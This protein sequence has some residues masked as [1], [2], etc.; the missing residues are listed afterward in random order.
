LLH[1]IKLQLAFSVE[2]QTLSL[3]GELWRASFN[4]ISVLS[5]ALYRVLDYKDSTAN[6]PRAAIAL[7]PDLSLVIEL[8]ERA[9]S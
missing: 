6:Q 2:S 1:N 4:C 3:K 9:R 5:L 7:S 8:K